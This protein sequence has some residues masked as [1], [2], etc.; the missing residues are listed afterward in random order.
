MT[1]ARFG[2][3]NGQD[4]LQVSLNGP[5][6]MAMQVLTWG[7]AMRDLVVPAAAGPQRVVLGLNSIEDY[8]AH[9]PYFGAVVGRYANRIGGARFILG[10]ETFHLH[11]NEGRN[12]LHGGPMGFGTRLWS[13]VDHTT[14]SVTLSLVS[15]DGDMGYPG[16][17]AATC[18]YTLLPG[19]RL[20]IA[21]EATCDRMTPVNLTT[22]GYF[23]LD[24]SADILAHHLMIAAD[25]ITPTRS[26]LIPTG[27]IKRVANTGYD[28]TS[29]RPIGA[30]ELMHERIHYDINYVL[31]GPYEELR[32]AATLSSLGSG[33][34][35]ELWTT[36]PGLQ[37]YDG[38]LINMPV[39]G[40]GGVRYGRHAGLCLE[41][42]RFPDSPN[43]AHFPS[44]ILPPGQVSRQITELR[45]SQ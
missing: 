1:V 9:S 11:P 26:D 34:S 27:E 25:Y 5:D 37:F 41:P 7:A 8:M 28:F 17:L 4:V 15:E 23:N 2:S 22:H 35:M 42:Q 36:E 45:F 38:H 10:G 3:L 39:P 29:L 14:S 6:G 13:L 24:G 21:L 31:R 33:V 32:H 19:C 18:T 40:L 20:R 44:S 16:R 30:A 12:Q 43:N